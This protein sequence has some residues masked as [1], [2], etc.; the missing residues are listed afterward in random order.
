MC[1]TH[2]KAWHGHQ[3]IQQPAGALQ[4]LLRRLAITVHPELSSAHISHVVAVPAEWIRWTS[5]ASQL[6]PCLAWRTAQ[7]KLEAMPLLLR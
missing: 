1:R 4:V 6:Q 2:L 5:A 3:I 7:N